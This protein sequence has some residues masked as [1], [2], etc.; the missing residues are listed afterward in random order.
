MTRKHF[1]AIASELHEFWLEL[2]TQS[3][4]NRYFSYLVENLIEEFQQVNPNFDPVR[5]RVAVY[6]EE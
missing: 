6:G 2:P 5:F 1:E 3:K 4:L